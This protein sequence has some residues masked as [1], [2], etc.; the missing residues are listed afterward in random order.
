M[1][2][3]AMTP[4]AVPLGKQLLTSIWALRATRG[5]DSSALDCP[6]A[7]K[8]MIS[9]LLAMAGTRAEIIIF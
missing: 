4:T 3:R 6:C 9:E 5:E 2:A 8:Q 7:A 1:W